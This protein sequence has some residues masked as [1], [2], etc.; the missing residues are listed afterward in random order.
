MISWSLNRDLVYEGEFPKSM[1]G[2]TWEE[3]LHAHGLPRLR[4]RK[5]EEW[6]GLSETGKSF[7][8]SIHKGM[9]I[10]GGRSDVALLHLSFVGDFIKEAH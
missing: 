9:A 10:C 4:D 1:Q 3:L 5:Q 6:P 7:L 2:Q 8:L